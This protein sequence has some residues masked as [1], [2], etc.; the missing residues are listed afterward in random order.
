MPHVPDFSAAR[1][2]VVTEVV[3]FVRR[4][5][6][7]GVD[8]PA[9]VALAA[10]EA[11]ATV[12]LDDRARVR[13][14][15]HATI[16]TDPDD[17]EA[18]AE[19]FKTFWYRLRTGLKATAAH[20]DGKASDDPD[21]SMVTEVEGSLASEEADTSAANEETMASDSEF[22]ETGSPQ[23]RR[24]SDEAGTPAERLAEESRTGTYSSAGEGD[25]VDKDA[26]AGHRTVT[27]ETMR[28]FERALATLSGRRWE[29]TDAGSHVDAR[30][31]LRT[32]MATG[33][34][35]VTLPRRRRDRTAFSAC[36]LVD[37]SR[38]VLDAVD[39]RFLLSVLDA[40]VADGRS[41]RVFFFD[42]DVRDVTDAFADGRDD[43]P[44]ALERAAVEWGGGTQIGS[45]LATLRRQWPD[46]VGRHA[47]TLV[48]SDGLEV[49]ELSE[50]RSGMS[51]LSR[52]SHAVVWLNPLAA[53]PSWEPKCRGMEVAVPYV[54]ALF[55]FGGEPD[56]NDAAQQLSQRGPGRTVGYRYDFRDR[57]GG[58]SS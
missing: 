41:V 5:R 18:F 57:A 6:D 35:P 52:R 31:A 38:S 58:T 22:G 34:V 50:L 11:L 13:A 4:L 42:T 55:A 23:S 19:A 48:V 45:S 43:P 54:D 12:G 25:E 27:A 37:V 29:Y 26:D 28:R 40:L 7:K 49:G 16:I 32:S 56:L 21:S 10:S 1:D 2:H 30:H 9:N 53:S 51:W 46:A 39:Q 47:V 14:A 44:V 33:G 36:V 8:I 20:D 17:E 24:V 3:L 15:L